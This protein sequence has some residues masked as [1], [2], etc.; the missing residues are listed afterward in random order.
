[1]S[2]ER[3]NGIDYSLYSRDNFDNTVKRQKRQNNFDN[4][5]FIKRPDGKYTVMTREQYI[6]LIS[7]LERRKRNNPVPEQ[8]QGPY[9]L[10]P[11]D[12][13][14]RVIDV[15]NVSDPIHPGSSAPKENACS[16][17]KI[18]EYKENIEYNNGQVDDFKQ[19]KRGDCYL[20]AAIDSIRRTENGQEILNKNVQK[21]SDGSYTV[22]LPG[23]VNVRNHYIQEGDGDK[24]AITGTYTITPEAIEK[25]KSMSGK[26]YAYGDIEVIALELAMEAFRA[27]VIQTNKALGIKSE[28][29]IA[30]QIAPRSESDPLSGG[31]M[32][33]AVYMLTGRK[34]DVY[35]APKEKRK[36]IKLYRPGEYGYVG[37]EMEMKRLGTL[38]AA[39]KGIIE[40]EHVYNKDSELQKMLDKYKGHEDEYSITVGVIV[41]KNGP[42]GST[43][44]GGGHALTVKKITDEY[45]EVVN[46]WDTTKVERIPRGDFE[47]MTNQLHVAPV[48]DNTELKDINQTRENNNKKGFFEKIREWLGKLNPFSRPQEPPYVP[49]NP[50]TPPNPFRPKFNPFMPGHHPIILYSD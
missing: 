10:G 17:D 2:L 30:G 4:L 36:N 16:P 7:E 20:L 19:G 8:K 42:D 3:L 43:K 5:V 18:Q 22:T 26:S 15:D 38:K 13:R 25:A 6:R 41:A 27:E 21:N 33:D 39:Q 47:A 44:A 14:S 29:F 46:P 37:E 31:Q 9:E 35:I 50:F 11:T 32:Y 45:V 48:A 12:G 28:K 34:S 24:C 23:A 1:M 40:V 49:P